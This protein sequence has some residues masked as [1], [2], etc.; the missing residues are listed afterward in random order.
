MDTIGFFGYVFAALAYAVFCFLLFAARNNTVFAK[1]LLLSSFVSLVTNLIAAAQIK[2]GFGLQIAMAMDCIKIAMWSVLI[3]LCN[4]ELS[5]L[6]KLLSNQYIR[7]YL[8][9]WL[10]LLTTC[11]GTTYLLE[12]SYQYLF[13][14]FIVLNLW[15]LVLL[16]Q[17][18]RSANDK[19]R[20]AIWPLVIA[21]ASISLFDFVIYAQATMIGEIDFDFWYSRG[22]IAAIVV[23]FLLVSTR[24]IRDGA[25]RIFVSRSVVFYSSMLMIAGIYLLVMAFAGYIINYFGGEWGSI[26]SIGFLVLGGIVLVVLLITESLRRRVKVFIAKNFFANKYEYRDEWLNLIEK[27]ETTSAQSPY[28]LATNIMMSKLNALGGAV[29]KKITNSQYKVHYEEGIVIDKSFS[30]QILRINSFCQDKGWIID[31]AEYEAAPSVYGDLSLDLA[32]C[33]A[34]NIRIIVPIHIGKAYYGC[35]IFTDTNELK[36]LNWEDRD[37][38]FAVAKQLGNFVSLHE[39]NDKLAESKQFDAFNRMSAFLVHDLKNVQAQLALITTNAEKHRNNPAFIDDVFETVESATERLAKVLSQLRK[40]QAAQSKSRMTELDV[41]V[42]KVVEQRN[43][44]KP[45]VDIVALESCQM[46]IDDDTFHSVLNH[47]IQN[48]QEATSG[49]GWVKVGLAANEHHAT[50][51]IEDNGSG[52]S[53]EFIEKRLF[54]PF[55]TTKGNAGMGI[56]VYEAKQFIESIAGVISVTSEEG[57]G[58]KF[59]VELP[60]NPVFQ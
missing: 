47:L 38:L 40:K 59:T 23:P 42:Q 44:I 55:D 1:W 24:R 27:I 36:Q 6:K 20:W 16:E 58:T 34:K 52:M 29:I 11:W 35:F 51:T 54:K 13:L 5:S 56:G 21:I 3:L 30:E 57:S 31:I 33:K 19:I 53:P 9:V 15:S 48:A 28:Q 2:L 37:L 4:T 17:L 60:L 12:Y 7:K 14:L 39:A 10:M 45:K 25:V 46:S 49:D 32:L 26:F 18:F 22:Y 41:V 43:V 8:S 50:I